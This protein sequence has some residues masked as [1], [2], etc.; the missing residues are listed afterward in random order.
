[1]LILVINLSADTFTEDTSTTNQKERPGSTPGKTAHTAEVGSRALSA[2]RK[3]KL[4]DGRSVFVICIVI[5]LGRDWFR[6]RAHVGHVIGA[7]S[8]GG[9][10]TTFY[11]W[12]PEIRHLRHSHVSYPLSLVPYSF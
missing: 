5:D 8:R 10:I 9:P 2:R 11:N 12:I 7:Q 3:L 6:L 4:E 1:M